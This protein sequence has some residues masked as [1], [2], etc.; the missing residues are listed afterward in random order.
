MFVLP[1]HSTYLTQPLDVGLFGP[2]QH[3]YSLMV[4]EM[5]N[6]DYPVM[7]KEDFFPILKASREKAYTEKNITSAWE[8][9]GLVPYNQRK[10]LDLLQPP[11]SKKEVENVKR[12]VLQTPR[13]TTDFRQRETQIQELIKQKVPPELLLDAFNKYAKGTNEK[14]VFESIADHKAKVLQERLLFKANHQYSKVRLKDR[15]Q[16]RAK[17]MTGATI[18]R[19]KAEIKEKERLAAEKEAEAQAKK[20]AKK[21]GKSKASQAKNARGRPTRLSNAS[22][23]IALDPIGNCILQTIFTGLTFEKRNLPLQKSIPQMH[24][25]QQT[26]V[27][28]QIHLTEALGS[29]SQQ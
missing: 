14:I 26:L 18:D 5:F 6:K 9:V 16:G 29:L 7:Q 8:E 15:S 20:A 25:T 12:K 27:L 22:D 19:L 21:K 2:L 13:K 4:R 3:F 28:T 17:L 11:K 24:L 1:A 23:C 10:I